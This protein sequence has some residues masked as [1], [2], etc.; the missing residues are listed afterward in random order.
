MGEYYF[1][2][3][4][5][6]CWTIFASL[7]DL[8]SREVANWL[9]FSLL[10]FALTYRAFYA[11]H[12]DDWMFFL[13]GLGGFVAM[14]LLALGFYYGKV[15]AGGDAKLLMGFGA[16]LPVSSLF[17]QLIFI[18][19]FL[20]ILFFSGSVYSL[21]YSVFLIKRNVRGFKVFFVKHLHNRWIQTGFVCAVLAS[22]FIG[23]AFPLTTLSIAF[24][25]FL[26]SVPFLSVYL[27]ALEKSCMIKLTLAK[28]L[29]EGDWLDT[30]VKLGKVWIYPSVHGLTQSQIKLLRRAKKSVF[31]KEGI[32]FVPAF[33]LALLF[34]GYVFVTLG[35]DWTSLLSSL[36]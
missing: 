16:L 32:P 2:F 26:L 15:F 10:A 31:I 5:A 14:Y 34:M 33:L 36:F 19:G 6:L 24:I 22:L 3:F 29:T 35:F 8:R 12:T 28:D 27:L 4:L 7:Q 13:A 20:L 25:V 9:T 18:V 30:K 21:I 23:F 11:I 1:L 17:N